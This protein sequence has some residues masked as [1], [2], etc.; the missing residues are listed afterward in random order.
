M[1]RPPLSVHT[2]AAVLSDPHA[3]LLADPAE[4]HR[5]HDLVAGVDEALG[6]EVALAERLEYLPRRASHAVVAVEG[7]LGPEDRLAL[8]ELDGRVEEGKLLGAGQSLRLGEELVI[9]P[10]DG[11]H[12][13]LRHRRRVSLSQNNQA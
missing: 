4:L 7:A 12:V 2:W 11:L 5:G 3:A 8:V 1:I 6:D 13:L 9:Q 10:S